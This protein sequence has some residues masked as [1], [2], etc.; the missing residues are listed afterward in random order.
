MKLLLVIA[1]A[2]VTKAGG[3]ATVVNV[4]GSEILE[5]G[6]SRGLQ[7]VLGSGLAEGLKPVQQ[8]GKRWI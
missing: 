7:R 2:A 5:H 6:F 1:R 8:N 4:E 3:R